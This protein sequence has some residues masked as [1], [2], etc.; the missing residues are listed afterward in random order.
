LFSNAV[1]HCKWCYTKLLGATGGPDFS[2]GGRGPLKTAADADVVLLYVTLLIGSSD[3]LISTSAVKCLERLVSKMT[4]DV[5]NRTL[6]STESLLNCS[7]HF[8]HSQIKTTTLRI[9][10]NFIH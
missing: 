3:W 8:C 9:G 4:Y 6:N 2:Q 1:Q 7:L 10:L 5:S